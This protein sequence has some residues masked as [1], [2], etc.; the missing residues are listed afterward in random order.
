MRIDSAI[1]EVLAKAE[2]SGNTLRLTEQLDRKTYQQ[3]SKVLSAIGGKWNSPKK[4]HI[5]ADDVE[6]ILQRIILTGEYTSE[7]TEY[8]FFPTPDELA[9]ETVRFANITPDDVCLEPSAGRGAIAKY[10][11]GCDCVELNPKNRAFLEEQGFKLV[12]DDFMTFEP[13]KKYSVIVMNP[14]FAKQQDIIHVTKAIHMATRCVVA[15]MSASVLFRTD[16]RTAEFRALVESYGGTIEPL[17]ESSF[18]ESG[19]AVNTCRVVVNKG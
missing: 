15:I 19:T 6:D 2:V 11:P 7:K 18:K 3:V 1:I 5:F 13:D 10:M 17:P 12:H 4:C 14:P 16:K 8:Q 9:A